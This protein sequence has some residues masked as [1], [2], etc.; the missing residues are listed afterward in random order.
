M[1]NELLEHGADTNA[2]DNEGI[3]PLHVAVYPGHDLVIED[4]LAYGAGPLAKDGYGVSPQQLAAME[5]RDEAAKKSSSTA[6]EPRKRHTVLD[7]RMI[8][9][10]KGICL[11]RRSFLLRL[12]KNDMPTYSKKTEA[13]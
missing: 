6:I 11:L 8:C 4:S 10:Q 5:V 13:R 7:L 3:T 9:A 2:K 12:L 1:L